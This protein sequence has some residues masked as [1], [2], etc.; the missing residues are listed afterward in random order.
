MK[1]KNNKTKIWEQPLQNRGPVTTEVSFLQRLGWTALDNI[2]MCIML[3]LTCFCAATYVAPWESSFTSKGN[4]NTVS[5]KIIKNMLACSW[6]ELLIGAASFIQGNLIN[7]GHS[8][9]TRQTVEIL[10]WWVIITQA[11]CLEQ[12]GTKTSSI[13]LLSFHISLLLFQTIY[14]FDPWRR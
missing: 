12:S 10:S 2:S 3:M 13:Y 1:K 11:L 6:G 4:S 7:T 14:Y 8:H 5:S 9:V